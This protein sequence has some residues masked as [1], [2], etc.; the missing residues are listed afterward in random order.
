VVSDVTEYRDRLNVLRR[1]PGTKPPWWRPFKRRLWNR[2]EA[3]LDEH[4]TITAEDVE[5][6]RLLTRPEHV[7]RSYRPGIPVA[8]PGDQYIAA[9]SHTRFHEWFGTACD[10]RCPHRVD[11]LPVARA[12][13]R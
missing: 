9:L 6:Y 5:A 4:S 10:H 2:I 12:R 1:Q 13:T 3:W 8:V 7:A 11:P